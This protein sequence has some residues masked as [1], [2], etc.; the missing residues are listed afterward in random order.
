M[1]KAREILDGTRTESAR[2]SA[3]GFDAMIAK[4]AFAS[5]ANA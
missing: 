3:N 4:M 1:L 2:H 5:L